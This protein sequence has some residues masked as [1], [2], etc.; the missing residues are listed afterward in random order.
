[1][2]PYRRPWMV[3]Q[4]K[5]SALAWP[6][7]GFYLDTATPLGLC[8]CSRVTLKPDSYS[9]MRDSSVKV[10]SP[11]STQGAVLMFRS[12]PKQRSAD[13]R[14]SRGFP[15][16]RA[17]SSIVGWLVCHL[18]EGFLWVSFSF[19]L[20]LP[21]RSLNTPTGL[22]GPSVPS[23]VPRSSG[24]LWFLLIHAQDHSGYRRV[25]RGG[26]VVIPSS[27]MHSKYIVWAERV[28]E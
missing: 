2:K 1:M 20:P 25:C 7:S 17:A 10:L 4:K 22:T 21:P 19:V 18:W 15:R 13:T 27:W 8:H 14:W 11:D 28:Y 12:A 6:S 23:R 3:P 5:V 26:F 16:D 9:A 24:C